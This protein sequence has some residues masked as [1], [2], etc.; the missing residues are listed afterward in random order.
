MSAI[1]HEY[2][3]IHNHIADN[4]VSEF[5]R[6]CI[7]VRTLVRYLVDHYHNATY[8]N[9]FSTMSDINSHIRRY[10]SITQAI[11]SAHLERMTQLMNELTSCTT[12]F[13]GAT[14]YRTLLGN[15]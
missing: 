1:T 5:D 8:I 6:S 4:L 9:I 13:N 2:T 10:V 3:R 11:Q 7:A 12:P 14:L 15:E